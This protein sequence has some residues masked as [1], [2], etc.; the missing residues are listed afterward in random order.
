MVASTSNTHITAKQ[1][2]ALIPFSRATIRRLAKDTKTDFPT[3]YVV[4]RSV[5]WSESSILEYLSRKAGFTITPADRAITAKELQSTFNKSH[6]WL[7]QSIKT[8]SIPE[9]FKIGRS[10]FWMQSQVDALTTE[11]KEVA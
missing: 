5:Y 4:G 8:G 1:V 7:W 9:P 2:Q 3:P 10:R 6:T 11:N